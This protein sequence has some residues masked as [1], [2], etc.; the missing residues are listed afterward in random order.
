MK[1]KLLMTVLFALGIASHAPAIIVETEFNNAFGSA[2]PIT[3]PITLVGT[4]NDVGT[5]ALGDGFDVD[6]FS[7]QLMAGET[8]TLQTTPLDDS[9]NFSP[10]TQIGVFDPSHMEVFDDDSGPGFGSLLTYTA[11]TSGTYYFAVTG[12]SDDDYNGT[13]DVDGGGHGEIG[14]YEL[15]LG[16]APEPAGLG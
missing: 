15:S 11:P 5:L 9:V 2:D 1:A 13:D 12:W 7:I 10:D 16:L 6:F 14:A 4:F 3:R 8:L